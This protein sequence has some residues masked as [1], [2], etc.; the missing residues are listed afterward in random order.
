MKKTLVLTAGLIALVCAMAVAEEPPW[1]DMENCVFC[2]HITAEKGL[3]EH[4]NS[5]YYKHS[6]GVLSVTTVDKD[7]REAL[8]RASK[9]MSAQGEK[10]MASMGK[11]EPPPYM[12]GHCTAYGGFI[13]AGVMPEIYNTD[14]GEITLWMSDK[15]E[16]VEKLHTFAQRSMDEREKMHS[17]TE[18]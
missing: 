18:H 10:M 14:Q 11:G 7:Y 12:C 13:M 3:M 8:N 9:A 2:K 17:E 1:F 5:T 16:L 15:P 4:M 6:K